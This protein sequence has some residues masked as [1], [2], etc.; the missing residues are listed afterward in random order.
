MKK[1]NWAKLRNIQSECKVVD[2]STRRLRASQSLRSDQ[3]AFFPFGRVFFVPHF[4]E[5]NLQPPANQSAPTPAGSSEETAGKASVCDSAKSR[6]NRAINKY[7]GLTDDVRVPIDISLTT[8]AKAVAT[9]QAAQYTRNRFGSFCWYLQHFSFLSPLLSL[10]LTPTNRQFQQ[11]RRRPRQKK[12]QPPEAEE[13]EEEEGVRG[14][15]RE[16]ERESSGIEGVSQLVSERAD[17]WITK[18]NWVTEHLR[19]NK[20]RLQDCSSREQEERE[21]DK[22]KEITRRKR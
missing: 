13:E 6:P 17:G 16:R 14:R 4:L 18:K 11:P 22:K 3:I 12:K 7:H 2:S 15:E 9:Q 8:F 19:T 5:P 10:S 20:N 1:D 21:D